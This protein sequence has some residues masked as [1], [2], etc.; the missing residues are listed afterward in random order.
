M[1]TRLLQ[2]S[3]GTASKLHAITFFI[4]ACRDIKQRG[5]DGTSGAAYIVKRNTFAL[6]QPA[7]KTPQSSW[8]KS[9]PISLSARALAREE[10]LGR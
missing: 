2:R 3:E 9:T 6:P 1:R 4:H 8:G 10:I 7:L 5:G